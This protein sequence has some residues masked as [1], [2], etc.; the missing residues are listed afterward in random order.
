MRRRRKFKTA[1]A[2]IVLLITLVVAALASYVPLKQYW[3][4][5]R[6]EEALRKVAAGEAI[7]HTLQFD[8]RD[9]AG[10][11]LP[12][13]V[14][15]VGDVDPQN[16]NPIVAPGDYTH[17]LPPGT[18]YTRYGI[19][20]PS[21]NQVRWMLE[22][23]KYPEGT[24]PVQLQLGFGPPIS[25]RVMDE[26]DIPVA[27][28][29]VELYAFSESIDGMDRVYYSGN[30]LTDAEGRWTFDDV[31]K[32]CARGNLGILHDSYASNVAFHSSFIFE[33]DTERVDVLPSG[34]DF[35]GFIK[36][37][38]GAPLADAKV[39]LLRSGEIS[40]ESDANGHFL[41][42]NS[43]EAYFNNKFLTVRL[44]GYATQFRKLDKTDW[45]TDY[46]VIL[47]RGKPL[48][49]TILDSD[50]RPKANAEVFV[51]IDTEY[52]N[53]LDHFTKTTDANGMLE[54][55]DA[56]RDV[57]WTFSASLEGAQRYESVRG[58]PLSPDVFSHTVQLEKA[59]GVVVLAEDAET[60]ESI[61]PITVSLGYV[62]LEQGNWWFQ[63]Y[64]NWRVP[65]G[66]TYWQGNVQTNSSGVF[67]DGFERDDD[68]GHQYRVHA[69]GYESADTRIVTSADDMA[70]LRVKLKPGKIMRLRAVDADGAPDATARA[71]WM[72]QNRAVTIRDNGLPRD[73]GEL[74][75]EADEAGWLVMPSADPA[76]HA[77]AILGTHGG[78]LADPSTLRSGQETALPPWATLD[79]SLSDAV[80]TGAT[81]GVRMAQ[82]QT[83]AG[84][85][86]TYDITVKKPVSGVFKAGRLFPGTYWVGPVYGRPGSDNYGD[87]IPWSTIEIK[88]GETAHVALSGGRV[89]TAQVEMPE[90]AWEWHRVEPIT[91]YFQR[92]DPP[93]AFKINYG[94]V[95]FNITPEGKATTPPL[96]PGNYLIDIAAVQDP[97]RAADD[98]SIPY[99][100]QDRR[101]S[102]PDEPGQDGVPFDIG[103]L[104][105]R[106]Q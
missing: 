101:F 43:H 9:S 12:E 22:V 73:N 61:A 37:D 103:S 53:Q 79:I 31:P 41:F 21:G 106:A 54:I 67:V 45:R 15:R 28:A 84:V 1:P 60:G 48:R 38:A 100:M 71:Y 46:E 32:E 23:Q 36:D 96:P 66:K 81:G 89:V 29:K 78:L 105:F 93:E 8:V 104:T 72:D 57:T 63:H 65:S 33:P 24:I 13:V 92:E 27:G 11:L 91:I 39:S 30:T 14:Y 99:I 97:G 76:T 83:I 94:P 2:V 80:F 86:V 17:P 18:R 70:Y 3:A 7:V 88:A 50:R 25:G 35:G 56:P 6:F 102:V 4:S 75:V 90:Q 49:V 74:I 95:Y 69:D 40:T 55:E 59:L 19:E 51:S 20:T 44:P 26:D 98:Y 64:M 85:E 58:L 68:Q 52:R 16:D 42:P 87:P 5:S 47:A 77:L 34:R 82:T 62:R 10:A